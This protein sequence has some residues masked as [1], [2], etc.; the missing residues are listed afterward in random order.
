M[1]VGVALGIASKEA[2]KEGAAELRSTQQS[3]I[4]PQIVIT[5]LKLTVIAIFLSA[6]L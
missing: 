4:Y 5:Q 2:M 6:G 1:L 3:S